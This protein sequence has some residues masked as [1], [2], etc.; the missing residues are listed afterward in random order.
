MTLTSVRCPK[1]G[2]IQMLARSCKSCGAAL[3]DSINRPGL[4]QVASARS[5]GVGTTAV[6]GEAVCQECGKSF[7]PSD[8]MRYGNLWVCAGCKP[9]FVQKLKEGHSMPGVMEYA[10]FWIRFGAKLID[11]VILGVVTLAIGMTGGFLTSGGGTVDLGGLILFQVVLVFF[12]YVVAAVYATWFVGKYDA[13][14]GKMVCKLR[15]VTEDGGK[16]SYARACGRHFAEYLSGMILAIGYLMAA[17][18]QERRTL[19]DRICSTRVVR[20]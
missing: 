16:V 17:F 5:R 13:T 11:G 3:D 4:S 15:V 19:H 20:A 10:G 18:D 14:P 7:S 9:V 12:Q 6:T 8:M 2:L 1:C